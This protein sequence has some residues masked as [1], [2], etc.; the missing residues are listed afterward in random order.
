MPGCPRWSC[1]V[2]GVLGGLAVAVGLLAAVVM[3]ARATA[4]DEHPLAVVQR[5]LAA[6]PDRDCDA[7]MDLVTREWWTSGG[8]I[9]GDDALDRCRATEGEAELD[10]AF[11]AVRVMSEQADQAVVE[12]RVTHLDGE[13]EIDEVHLRHQ[14]GAWRVDP[15]PASESDTGL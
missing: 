15:W 14:D 3:Y 2:P 9:S 10:S 7:L 6:Y 4:A 5:Y 11:E 8:R 12:I 13:V 1:L